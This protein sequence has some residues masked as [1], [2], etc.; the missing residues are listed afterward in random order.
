MPIDTY[1]R[2]LFQKIHD[3]ISVQPESFEMDSWEDRDADC[4]TTRCVAGWAISLTTQTDLG[5]GSRS[6]PAVLA[7]AE[8]HGIYL[9]RVSAPYS[10]LARKLLGLSPDEAGYLFYTDEETAAEIVK[11][12]AGGQFEQAS[13][14]MAPPPAQDGDW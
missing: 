6:H 7:L 11:L 5:E 12:M 2:E 3:V 10:A 1:N 9:P 4:G 8:R 14:L 13:A